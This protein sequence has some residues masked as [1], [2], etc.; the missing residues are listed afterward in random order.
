VKATRREFIGRVGVT[1]GSLIGARWAC[2]YAPVPPTYTSPILSSSPGGST[3]PNWSTLRACWVDLDHPEL[4]SFEDT[5]FSRDLRQRHEHALAALVESKEIDAAV[6]DEIAIAFE[7][8]I[9]HI[10][11][12][13]ATCYI[14]LPPVFA[15]REDLVKQAELLEELSAEGDIASKTVAQAQ[16]ALERDIAWLAQFHAGE[17][18]G[19]LDGIEITP[20]AA[21]AARI[22]VELLLGYQG[23]G[24][25]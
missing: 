25:W 12:Q 16:A 10:Q 19:E 22:L 14:A 15:P 17:E 7:E 3:D 8:A 20:E 23:L 4:Q 11:R 21:E 6:A 18:P 5:G 1:L 9:A 13:Q 2:C 24:D